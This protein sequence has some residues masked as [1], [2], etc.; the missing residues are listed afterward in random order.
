MGKKKAVKFGPMTLVQYT[1]SQQK[2][3]KKTKP[4][5]SKK[6]NM[7]AVMSY[8]MQTCAVTNPFCPEAIGARWPDNSMTK[9]VGWSITG[10]PLTLSS[11]ANGNSACLFRGS[12]YQYVTGT[13]VGS[14]ITYPG[15]CLAIV[16]PPTAV[17]RARLTS[18]GLKINCNLSKMTCT[19]V[20]RIRLFSPID[21]TGLN[22]VD[23][24]SVAA[25]NALDI[26]LS[27]LI[28]KDFYIIPMP[29]GE[30]ARLFSTDMLNSNLDGT[31]QNS[32]QVVQLFVA[33]APVSTA[34]VLAVQFYYN[35]EFCFT[36]GSSTTAFAQPPPPNLPVVREANASVLSK[37]G[38]F[39]EG[40]AQ[41][42]DNFVK[43]SAAKYLAAGAAYAFGGPAAALQAGSG[44]A[45]LANGQP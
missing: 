40:T 14:T 32:W 45:M 28:D 42:V 19:G 43:S 7:S 1:K 17:V 30:I 33:G 13:T 3:K 18:W 22:S 34:G 38:N 25:D 24:N 4:R 26:P 29:L 37:V 15:T 41:K 8:A 36:D 5:K 6:R 44:M 20:V 27:R 2:K 16:N 35:Y 21:G 12:Q 9:S 39:I 10:A 23:G 11:D 31:F